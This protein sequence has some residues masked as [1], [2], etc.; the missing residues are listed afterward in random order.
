MCVR[1]RLG[2]RGGSRGHRVRSDQ[3]C[4]T[5]VITILC[6]VLKYRYYYHSLLPFW[7]VSRLL[8]EGRS[9]TLRDRWYL[10][11]RHSVPLPSETQTNAMQ[12]LQHKIHTYIYTINTSNQYT[13]PLIILPLQQS[14]LISCAL[15]YV[16]TV[17]SQ[18]GVRGRT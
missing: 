1:R 17:P 8:T 11:L 9:V 12:S 18:Y 5:G 16:C 10:T 3:I 15:F 2:W 14:H 13:V 6:Y 7:K 4:Y